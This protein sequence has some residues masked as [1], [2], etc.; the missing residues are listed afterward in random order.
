MVDKILKT[1]AEEGKKNKN[2][3]DKHYVEG[4]GLDEILND[5]DFE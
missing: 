1:F 5:K 2:N 4:H 3:I